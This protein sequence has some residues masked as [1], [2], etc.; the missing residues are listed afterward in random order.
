MK[1]N[2]NMI[3]SLA[4]FALIFGN[5]GIFAQTKIYKLND[6]VAPSSI[7]FFS[8]AVLEDISGSVEK[9]NFTSSISFDAANLTTTKGTVSLNVSGMK[10]GMATRDK[11]LSGVEWLDGAKYP[12]ISFDLL[13]LEAVKSSVAGN[14]TIITA[15]AVGKFNM[16]GISKDMSIP[17]T[18][19]YIPESDAT[20]KRAGGDFLNVEGKF[21]VKW[22]DFGVK[23]KKGTE[24]KVGET[25]N[26][27]FKLFFNNK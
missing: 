12:N 7:T 18:I 2:I 3:L 23:G 4:L 13:K 20:R 21:D 17:V 6:N 26:C 11:H 9:G 16:H 19:T 1:K 10:T 15:A 14:K 25:I 24:D 27:E 8:K 22:K 5:F